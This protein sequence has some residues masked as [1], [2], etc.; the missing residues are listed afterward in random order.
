MFSRLS[1]FAAVSRPIIQTAFK[2]ARTFCINAAYLDPKYHI[3]MSHN[4]HNAYEDIVM[5]GDVLLPTKEMTKIVSQKYMP[6]L[7]RIAF[8]VLNKYHVI[9]SFLYTL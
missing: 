1:K 8:E 7:L 9:L 3:T 4:P 2:P 5:V 6:D